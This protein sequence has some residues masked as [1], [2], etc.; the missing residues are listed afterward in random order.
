MTTKTQQALILAAQEG[1]SIGAAARRVGIRPTTAYAEARKR[2]PKRF[3]PCC[4]GEIPQGHKLAP[5]V[6]IVP[7]AW[8][9]NWSLIAEALDGANVPIAEDFPK[10]RTT[11][12][13][14]SREDDPAAGLVRFIWRP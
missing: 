1:L 6:V 10:N 5:I 11:Q 8:I 4:R 7:G 12:G 14:L 2:N 9:G 13:E 3:C